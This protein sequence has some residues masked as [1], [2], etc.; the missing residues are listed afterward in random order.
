MSMHVSWFAMLVLVFV[1]L[2]AM[3][4]VSRWIDR[5]VGRGTFSCTGCLGMLALV[6]LGMLIWPMLAYHEN[7]HHHENVAQR[8]AARSAPY[9][10]QAPPWHRA[11]AE[12]APP[13]VE[14]RESDGRTL[15][16]RD[17]GDVAPTAPAASGATL[18]LRLDA[19]RLEA[20]GIRPE[21][22]AQLAWRL[23]ERLSQQASTGQQAV[24]LGELEQL[25][26]V[27]E[28]L[29]TEEDADAADH[30]PAADG[31]TA[32]HS[33]TP[34]IALHEIADL[35]RRW[36]LSGRP[37]P[38]TALRI[39]VT[40]ASPELVDDWNRRLTAALTPLGALVDEQVPG[41]LKLSLDGERIQF[42]WQPQAAL[43]LP[44]LG[45]IVQRVLA[46]AA[47]H[48]P[49]EI[50]LSADSP[51]DAATTDDTVASRA[52]TTEATT[53]G[54]ATVDAPTTEA[55]AADT[56]KTDAPRTDATTTDVV[57]DSVADAQPDAD[58]ESAEPAESA[59]SA[60]ADV[61]AAHEPALAAP[62]SLVH[63]STEAAPDEES[64]HELSDSSE[65]EAAPAV[66]IEPAPTLDAIPSNDNGA[67][68]AADDAPRPAWVD[69]PPRLAGSAYHVVVRTGPFPTREECEAQLFEALADAGHD[70]VGRLLGPAAG[71]RIAL[72]PEYLW[73]WAVV[74]KEQ[75]PVVYEETVSTSFG[76]MKQLYWQLSFGE[77][78]A[79]DA[80]MAWHDYR[81]RSRLMLL[82]A[83][84]GAVVALLATVY[85]YLRLDTATRGYYSGRLKLAAAC[86]AMGALAT[87]FVVLWGFGG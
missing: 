5:G 72:D 2:V 9:R 11:A 4:Q 30:A 25:P 58:V 27:E 10:H 14:R 33:T 60:S 50:E 66:P 85:G 64:T 77:R 12:S 82:G 29:A 41:A 86:A 65:G 38:D 6:G 80:R 83:A 44:T 13:Q 69:M 73:Q 22:V 63:A 35:T 67:D 42:T 59:T 61:V 31:S 34:T 71:H 51:A 3:I 24:A 26:V 7:R 28:R 15:S 62:A 52:A 68:V 75:Q 54:E 49:I 20:R 21:Q 84:A 56:A 17:Q 45:E 55:T 81:I 78:Q 32:E 79:R 18:E 76:P 57:P 1:A 37:G 46:R 16:A 23:V 48:L 53:A 8:D 43:E 47:A 87:T 19:A 70:Y 74:R 36:A 40:G 39:R